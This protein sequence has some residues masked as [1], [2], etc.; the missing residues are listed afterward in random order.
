MTNEV[1]IRLA[2][3]D[4]AESIQRVARKAWHAAYEEI[5]DPSRIDETVDAW[6]A[7]ERLIADDITPTDRPFFVATVGDEVTGF[8]EAVPEDGDVAHLYRIYVAPDYWGQGIGRSLLERLQGDLR[9]R[10]FDTLVLSVFAENDVGV[11][12]YQSM[13]FERT[14]E[15]NS[16]RFEARQYE[17]KKDL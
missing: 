5:I 14:A 7:P 1:T 10:G 16:E 6:Y 15:T 17:Y 3:P 8:A 9:D 13:G 11:E 2:A 12:F 4:E